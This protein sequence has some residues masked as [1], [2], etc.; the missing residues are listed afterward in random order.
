MLGLKED[1]I[2]LLNVST[3]YPQKNIDILLNILNK[4]DERFVL[5][6]IDDRERI[7]P[8]FKNKNQI[9]RLKKCQLR[10]ILIYLILQMS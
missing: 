9:I 3:D 5:I 1:K 4:L 7:L 6:R 2:Y 8:K 10:Y